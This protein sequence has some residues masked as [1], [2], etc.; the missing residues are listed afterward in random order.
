VPRHGS[1][2][3]CLLQAGPGEAHELCSSLKAPCRHYGRHTQSRVR[4]KSRTAMP[5]T[6]STDYGERAWMTMAAS[7][8]HMSLLHPPQH[9]MGAYH[10]FSSEFSSSIST[11]V[12]GRRVVLHL[13]DQ[14]AT[15]CALQVDQQLRGAVQEPGPAPPHAVQQR[16]G[17]LPP[18]GPHS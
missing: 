17:V 5:R 4:L 8:T 13:P 15:L 12:Y 7:K 6:C 16:G 18:P 14:L 3:D 9:E 11:S 10:V 1:S 2:V